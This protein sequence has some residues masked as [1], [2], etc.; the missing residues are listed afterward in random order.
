MDDKRRKNY[1]QQI[2]E[3]ITVH[4]IKH[5]EGL[6]WEIEVYLR[7]NLDI[8]D[9]LESWGVADTHYV[10]VRWGLGNNTQQSTFSVSEFD[11]LTKLMTGLAKEYKAK[12]KK[13]KSE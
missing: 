13:L 7:E 10:E 4:D 3:N 12:Y 8:E 6:D 11:Q 1:I 5:A 9:D 2:G